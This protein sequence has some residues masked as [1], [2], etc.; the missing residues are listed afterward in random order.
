M[1]YTYVEKNFKGSSLALID[2]ANKIIAEYQRDGYILT[3]RQLYYQLV[4]RD[5]IPNTVTEYKRA[6]SIFNDARLA[7]LMDWDA[8][9]DRTREFVRRSRWNDGREILDASARSFHMD[10]WDNQTV[11][12][13]V[14]VEKEALVGVFERVCREYDVP[15][16]AA[17]GYPS[18]SVIREFVEE[19][20]IPTLN[21]GQEVAIFHFGDHDPSGIDMSRDLQERINLFLES[22][23]GEYEFTRCALN[24]NQIVEQRPPENPAKTTDSRF[25]SY[26]SKFGSSSWELDALKPSYLNELAKVHIL[27]LIDVDAWEERKQEIEEIR[28]RIRKIAGEF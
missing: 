17:R 7:G 22:D 8:I 23:A 14:I 15:L 24:M 2:I 18:V 3:I 25:E 19:D 20:I 9:E 13:F 26:L 28:E 21:C 6:A 27:S 10:M 12:P 4:A 16:L 5:V 1:R 11:R